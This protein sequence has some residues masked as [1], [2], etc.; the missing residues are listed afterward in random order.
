MIINNTDQA[1]NLVAIRACQ[2]VQTPPQTFH[3][4]IWVT[5]GGGGWGC[6][7]PAA[8]AGGPAIPGLSFGTEGLIPHPW[9]I[10]GTPEA[11]SNLADSGQQTILS[12]SVRK[13]A[14]F[15][16]DWLITDA[17]E[18]LLEVCMWQRSQ[19][20]LLFSLWILRHHLLVFPKGLRLGLLLSGKKC[21]LF[22][23]FISFIQHIFVEF[24]PCTVHSAR[25][26]GYND[27]Q[28]WTCSLP[29]WSFPARE[30]HRWTSWLETARQQKERVI[31]GTRKQILGLT[32]GIRK[33]FQKKVQG[34]S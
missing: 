5:L 24:L 3:A 25:H 2:L 32:L 17:K 34:P 33:D 6:P 16:L 18:L 21:H 22:I 26:W 14:D 11:G 29:P 1:A 30:G 19:G 10:C 15:S 23:C 12:F 28:P 27:E 20:S 9:T 7:R 4:D 13:T 31:Y 8:L